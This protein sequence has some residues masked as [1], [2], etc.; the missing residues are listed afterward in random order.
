MGGGRGLRCARA[1]VHGFALVVVMLAAAC[2]SGSD[3]SSTGATASPTPP[4]KECGAHGGDCRLRAVAA[5][6]DLRV[7]TAVQTGPLADEA[8]YRGTVGREFNSITAE[9]DMKWPTI[10]PA[11]DRYDF[12]AA[13]AVVGF[14]ADH[15][16]EVRGHTLLWGQ[17]EYTTV[18]DYVANATGPDELRAYVD[19]HITTVV[20]RYRG[21]VQRWDVVNEPLDT[22][23]TAMENNVFL[24]LL[25]EGYIADAFRTAHRA[26]PAAELW[27]NE[28][29][30]E[31]LPAKAQAFADLVTRLVADKV[32]IDG[33]GLQTHLLAGVPDPVAFR[34]LVRRF[35][36]LGL[37]VAITEMDLPAGTGPDRLERQARGYATTI[38]A[39]LAGPRC[40]EVT[41]WGFTDRHTW[42]DDFL[43]PGHDPLLFDRDYQPK[44]AYSAVREQLAARR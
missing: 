4:V 39:C 15:D 31:T 25:G 6:A 44:P 26:D 13:D 14:A 9:N 1:W 32:P 2:S 41:F 30:L 3:G 35:A 40:R 24:R 10:H 29:V 19:D 5:A 27:L 22:V 37:D 20:R 34:A 16:M 33:I 43:G 38:G 7:G 28:A 36:D 17:T 12:A 11:A 18:P 21:R 23:G 42:I 8:A